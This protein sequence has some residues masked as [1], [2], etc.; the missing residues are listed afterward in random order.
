M[1]VAVFRKAHFNAAHRLHQPEWTDSRNKEVFG[2][3]NNP[4]F[5]GHNYEMDVKVIGEIDP[6]TG[7]LIDLGWLRDLIKTEIEDRFDHKNLNVETEEFANLNPTAENIC[8]VIW[9]ILRSKLES[10]YDL[11]V[12]L[13]ET[14][15][16]YVEYPAF[17]V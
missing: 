10:K 11:Q 13:Y 12:R 14:P 17:I 15:R 1:K 8:V 6:E 7:M 9:N 16:N 5:H 3:C 4:N 2:L